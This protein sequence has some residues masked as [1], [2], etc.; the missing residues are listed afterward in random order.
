MNDSEHT[1]QFI[2]QEDIERKVVISLNVRIPE[3]GAES[4]EVE[5]D[6]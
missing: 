5:A 2:S 1:S 4:V 6:F 3:Q